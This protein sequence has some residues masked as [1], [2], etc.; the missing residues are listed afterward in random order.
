MHSINYCLIVQNLA[1]DDINFRARGFYLQSGAN[2]Q[3]FSEPFKLFV[4]FMKIVMAIA[5]PSC[6]LSLHGGL[7]AQLAKNL[8]ASAGDAEDVGLN[9]GLGR[10][11]GEGNGNLLQYSFLGYPM[12]RGACWATVHGVT[13]LLDPT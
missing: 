2:T 10:C 4:R 8:P 5:L 3:R 7:L 12:H 6:F 11:P 9:P 13:K 1:K